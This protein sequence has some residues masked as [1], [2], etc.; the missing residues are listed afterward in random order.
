MD[1]LKEDVGV[2]VSFNHAEAIPWT[3]SRLNIAS[4]KGDVIEAHRI[5]VGVAI[6]ATS[7]MKAWA[8]MDGAVG[9]FERA[10]DW[11][12]VLRPIM[13]SPILVVGIDSK[14]WPEGAFR[15]TDKGN[16]ASA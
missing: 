16:R 15:G 10:W 6:F 1:F 4:E 11:L 12:Q 7:D 3:F 2:E 8:K 5:V 13:T 14:D 9:T